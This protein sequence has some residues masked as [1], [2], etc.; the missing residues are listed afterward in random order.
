[1]AVVN[2]ELRRNNQTLE[3]RVDARTQ[4]LT[5][6]TAQLQALA[7]D[8][9][10][11]EERERQR[12][13][14]IIHDHLQQ[15]L[16]VARINLGMALQRVAADDVRKRLTDLDNVLAESLDITRS[17]T[18]ELSPAILR[19][20]GLSAALSWLGRW[21]HG[22]FGLQVSVKS[23]PEA[24]LDQGAEPDDETRVTLF[25]AVRE[26]LFNVVKHAQTANASVQLGQT[27]DGRAC[28]VVTDEGAGFD[29]ET[30]RDWDGTAGGFG[31]FSLR[32]RLE[33]L[34]GQFE[35][36]SS[37]GRGTSITITGPP[38]GAVKP[39]MPPTPSVAPLA[40]AARR[41]SGESPGRPRRKKR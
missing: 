15:L 4:D 33:M 23:D 38:P 1:M 12:V 16:S 8:L 29:P 13:A 34:G 5:R 30:L 11:A 36:S 21:Y 6:R 31:L 25:R 14:E 40:I 24:G 17:L 27:A 2:A 18:A 26:L 9:T 32:E 37:P 3:A 19:R 22:R 7:L 35:V 41:R 39:E 20:S 10:R 28:I